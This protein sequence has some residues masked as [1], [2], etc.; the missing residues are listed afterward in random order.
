M[1]VSNFQLEVVSSEG[2]IFSGLSKRLVIKGKEGELGVEP[3]HSHLLTAIV[4]GF[5]R[6]EKTEGEPEIFFISGGVL[7]IQPTHV[8]VLADTIQRPEE[9]NEAAA[10]EAQLVARKMLADKTLDVDKEAA[11]QQLMEATAKLSLLRL[12][13]QKRRLG[14]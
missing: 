6:I 2:S 1:T 14:S 8:S 10:Q 7:E 13:R 11:R 3:G 5:I 9:V 12:L 4:P